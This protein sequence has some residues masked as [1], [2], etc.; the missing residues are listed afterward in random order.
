MWERSK[1]DPFSESK[2]QGDWVSKRYW[3]IKDLGHAE[4]LNFINT[5]VLHR[6]CPQTHKTYN[7]FLFI[8][9]LSRLINQINSQQ[10]CYFLINNRIHFWTKVWT[11]FSFKSIT[12][13][14]IST[15][16]D[17]RG[18]KVEPS[19]RDSNSAKQGLF[20]RPFPLN[21]FKRFDWLCQFSYQLPF[22]TKDYWKFS[23]QKKY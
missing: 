6:F 11:L 8:I 1:A 14:Q 19:Q 17:L 3:K 23:S 15:K 9:L 16:E 18:R 2:L 4:V 20:E 10:T 21:L 13:W 7:V 5:Y 12:L 22:C